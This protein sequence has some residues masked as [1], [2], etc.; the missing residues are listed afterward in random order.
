M[1]KFIFITALLFISSNVFAGYSSNER[2][3]CRWYSNK[4]TTTARTFSGYPAIDHD[5]DCNTSFS[6]LIK[7]CVFQ[8]VSRG[9]NGFWQQGQVSSNICSRGEV[10]NN[11]DQFF[12]PDTNA[13]NNIEESEL[14]ASPTIFDDDTHAIRLSGISG[15]IKL[16]KNNGFYS[17]MRFS[18][19]KPNDDLVNSVEDTTMDDSE[20][21]H[22]LE[23]KVTDNGI[24]FNGDLATEE[25][26][27]KFK[28][29]DDGKDIYVTFNDLSVTVP[30]DR[31]ISLDD[32]AVQMDGDGAPDTESNIAK[33]S[34]KTDTLVDTNNYKFNIHPN[35]VKD[36]IN[37][38]FS[39]NLST[40]NTVIEL[41]NTN[42]RKVKEMFNDIIHE[43]DIKKIHTDISDLPKGNYYVMVNCNGRKLVKQIIKN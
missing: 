27:E 13:V 20:V 19:W 7:Y 8:K 18:V 37:I 30:V 16:N 10:I 9:V 29:V 26:K 14:T 15:S 43:K 34:A 17:S 35:P 40:G 42:G 32:M 24:Y 36:F 33:M 39:D 2:R 28:I 21:L 5:S 38:E 25:V 12:L 4:Y 1:K 22:Q 31:N 6:Q 41:Y 3:K 23:I 11:F